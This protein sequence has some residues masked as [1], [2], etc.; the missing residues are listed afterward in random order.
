[1]A[2]P[3]SADSSVT[4]L[5][6]GIYWAIVTMTTVGYGDKTPKTG[7]GCFIAVLWMMASPVRAAEAL[8]L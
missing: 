4:S 1:L 5:F 6:D 7:T 2:G 3:D 8:A